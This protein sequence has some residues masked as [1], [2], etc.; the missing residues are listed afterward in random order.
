MF[1]EGQGTHAEVG[2]GDAARDCP[3]EEG[4]GG[5]GQLRICSHGAHCVKYQKAVGVVSRAS[6]DPVCVCLKD[7]TACF[8]EN[9]PWVQGWKT[10]ETLKVPER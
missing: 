1:E 4:G 7:H 6:W 2:S 3:P 9:R 8:T 10:R 5:C